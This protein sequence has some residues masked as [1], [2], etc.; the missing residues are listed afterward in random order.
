[1]P[2]PLSRRRLL[3]GSLAVASVTALC[4]LL[5]ACGDDEPSGSA[6]DE[7][8]PDQGPW[9]WT[10]DLGQEVSLDAAPTRIA[11]YGDAAAALINFGITPVALFH[12]MDPEQDS[13]F[14]DLDLSDV[15]VVGSAYGEINLEQLAAT[16]P[17]LVVTTLYDGDEPDS[18]YGFK[19]AAQ[20]E[21]IRA[22][23]PVV[24]VMQTGS[25]IDVIKKNEALVASLGV[26]VESGQVAEDR[27]A[28][29]HASEALTEAAGSGLTVLPIYGED[30]NYYVA[31]APDDPALRYYSELGLTFVPVEG[32]DYYWE[33]LSWE[34]ADKYQPDIVLY[35]VR[36]S[37]TPE[38]LMDQPVFARLEAAKAGQ[39][40]PWKFKSMDYRA[41]TGYLE[42]LAGWLG[43]DQKVT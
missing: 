41:Q 4:G 21:K 17:E 23:A 40:H 43:S 1:M 25:A 35:S 32:K 15:E 27:H 22:I 42:E 26:D 39:L 16:R 8:A 12:Y 2:S 7:R 11:A 5:T 36:D 34:Q 6:G 10:D 14:E 13:T 28:F 24:G 20:I 30:A 3:G 31:K 18:M 9:T 37:F 33:V 29:E 19:D 38:Q